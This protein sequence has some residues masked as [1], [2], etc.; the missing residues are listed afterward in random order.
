VA[1]R[2][3]ARV[4]TGSPPALADALKSVGLSVEVYSAMDVGSAAQRYVQQKADSQLNA[5]RV[6]II[7]A[8]TGNPFFT[9]DTAAALRACE[10][11]ADAILKATK[12][13]GIYTADPMVDASA[14]RYER[15]S[16]SDALNQRLQVMD[17]TAFSLC[18]DNEM[19]ILVFNFHRE[20]S[21]REVIAG[22]LSHATLVA[23]DV[24]G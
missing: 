14:T 21:L 22:D 18:M 10:L 19:P 1:C 12:V 13:D 8:G 2:A 24:G 4:W 7:A 23:S 9:T 17:A 11:G 5:G 15:I 6:V 16:Y 3:A 20:D